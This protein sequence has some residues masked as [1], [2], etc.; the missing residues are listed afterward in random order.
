MDNRNTFL[1]D[2]LKIAVC[3]P[4]PEEDSCSTGFLRLKDISVMVHDEADMDLLK[5]FCNTDGLIV[6]QVVVFENRSSTLL[7]LCHEYDYQTK[8]IDNIQAEAS[9]KN[10]S[11]MQQKAEL[12]LLLWKPWLVYKKID[13]Y[14]GLYFSEGEALYFKEMGEEADKE[15]QEATEAL[16]RAQEAEDT[17][18]AEAVIQ[19]QVKHQNS[20]EQQQLDAELRNHM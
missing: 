1:R 17:A 2:N 10:H 4:G 8:R 19:E 13:E 3:V 18:K 14:I 12:F 9:M 6:S 15:L 20:A 16:K 7:E 11:D 5:I